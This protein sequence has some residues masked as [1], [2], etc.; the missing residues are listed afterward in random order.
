MTA[1]CVPLLLRRY[2]L[3]GLID[4]ICDDLRLRHEQGVACR[5]LGD[6]RLD[7]L[8]HVD[9]H[10]LVECL[11][12]GRDDCPARLGTPGGVFKFRAEG[13]HVDR[14]LR[15]P[16]KRNIGVADVMGETG[17]ELCRADISE[18]I[19]GGLDDGR[20]RRQDNSYRD[21]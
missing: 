17:L 7:A 19:L 18:T 15:V 4:R 14:H 21:I 11:V 1:L 13:R 8:C 9:Q 16:Q 20:F 3:R 12:F 6:L 2:S 5:H 10:C